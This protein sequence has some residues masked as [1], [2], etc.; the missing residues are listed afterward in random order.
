MRIDVLTLFPEMFQAVVGRSILGRASEAGL[1]KI[2]L[3]NF[4]DFTYDRHRTV[5]DTPYGGGSGML[6]KPE[7]VFE[8]VDAIRAEAELDPKAESGLGESGPGPDKTP[9]IILTCPSGA[10]FNQEKARELAAKEHLIIICGHY[11]GFDERVREGLVDEALSVG[12]FVLTG[13]ELPAMMII[14]AVAR[15]IPGV[16]AEG[17]VDEESFNEGLL[18]YPQY[19]RPPEYRGMPVP[20]VLLSG[21]HGRIAKW[22]RE[23]SIRR[24]AALRPDL[25]SRAVLSREDEEILARL[26][27]R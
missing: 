25:L 21:D 24:T 1:I 10:R 27:K 15:L 2:G 12:D 8:A 13:G 5:D 7:P 26:D 18:E 20:E 22:R 11:E 6:L 3:V 9:Y 23:Q 19:T 16:L 4:R 14:D 17:S